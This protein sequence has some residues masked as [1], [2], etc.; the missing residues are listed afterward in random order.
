MMP[1]D[2]QMWRNRYGAYTLRRFTAPRKP[3]V[4]TIK[5]S[6]ETAQVMNA[7]PRAEEHKHC[8]RQ[9]ESLH[10]PG[11]VGNPRAKCSQEEVPR[12]HFSEAADVPR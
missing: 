12:H 2:G 6:S 11:C 8:I 9:V 10:P 4:A 5:G 7:S 1:C 3:S